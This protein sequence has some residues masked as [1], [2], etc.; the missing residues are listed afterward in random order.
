MKKATKA[1]VKEIIEEAKELDACFERLSATRM[2]VLPI[3]VLDMLT[4]KRG[5]CIGMVEKNNHQDIGISHNNKRHYIHLKRD[6][7]H[8]VLAIVEKIEE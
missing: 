1:K 2:A 6:A 7:K 4:N 3:N 5:L 8:Y